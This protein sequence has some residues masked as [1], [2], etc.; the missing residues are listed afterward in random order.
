MLRC[1]IVPINYFMQNRSFKDNFVYYDYC[2]A[3]NLI[4]KMLIMIMMTVIQVVVWLCGIDCFSS[5]LFYCSQYC[6][7]CIDALIKVNILL[8]LF[9]ASF[10]F[11]ISN[12]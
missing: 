12:K 11:M 2:Y 9:K 1:I 8:F 5:I 3:Y 6:S 4:M 10:S 7:L